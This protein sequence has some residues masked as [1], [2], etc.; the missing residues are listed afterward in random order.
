VSPARV[1]FLI[2]HGQADQSSTDYTQTVRGRQWDPALDDR[3]R[4]QVDLLTRG[5]LIMERPGAIYTSPLQRARQTI[6]PF[7]DSTGMSV[8]TED[9]LMEA[10]IGEW[11]GMSFEDILASDPEL[12]H[13]FRSQRAIWHRAPG[14]ETVDG[15]RERV[16]T[17]IDAILSRHVSG[18]VF[19]VAHGG[20][21]NAYVGP[22]LGVGQEM[23]FIPENTSLN[24][25]DVDGPSRRVRFLNDVLHLSDP[26]LFDS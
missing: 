5:L 4:E 17:V 12:L 3:G 2:R 19:V 13:L 23:F 16:R 10:H 6:G 7:A 11:E 25:L 22:L 24:L 8:H 20:V 14:G 26:K 1:L 21:I 9:D 15:F 18:D